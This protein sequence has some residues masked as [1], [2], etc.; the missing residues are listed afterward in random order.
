MRRATSV[1]DYKDNA[2]VLINTQP[3]KTRSLRQWRMTSAGEIEP[4]V[5]KRYVKEAIALV[6]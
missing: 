6:S 3:G 2:N 1:D 5:I 4:A